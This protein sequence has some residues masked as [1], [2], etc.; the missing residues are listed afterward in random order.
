M[1]ERIKRSN[2]PFLRRFE[3][4]FKK[5]ADTHK[6]L[7]SVPVHFERYHSKEEERFEGG[8]SEVNEDSALSG[9]SRRGN[10]ASEWTD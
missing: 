2:S 8:S 4:P 1:V 3:A 9:G 7:H 10:E 5:L 6:K